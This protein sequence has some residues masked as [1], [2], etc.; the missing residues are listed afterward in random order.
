VNERKAEVGPVF[1]RK[2]LGYCLRR[3]TKDTVDI[4]VAPK[5]LD[6]FKQRIRLITRWAGCKGMVSARGSC[7][8]LPAGLEV[9]LPACASTADVHRLGFMDATP[10]ARHLPQALA[11][12]HDCLQSPEKPGGYT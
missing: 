9:L 6:T 11:D 4:A 12:W 10:T 3:W 7:E 5:A 8:G 2:F 1:G